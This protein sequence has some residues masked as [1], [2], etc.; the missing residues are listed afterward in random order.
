MLVL[1][2]LAGCLEGA[3]A[4]IRPV[5]GDL[6]LCLGHG[7]VVEG[8][9][10]EGIDQLVMARV[11]RNGL[12]E[13]DIVPVQVAAF[14]RHTAQPGEAVR[15]QCV[16]VQRRHVRLEPLPGAGQE[17]VDLCTRAAET[18]HAVGGGDRHQNLLRIFRTNPGCV[19]G[20]GF[21]VGALVRVLVGRDRGAFALGRGEKALA[22]LTVIV[23]KCVI[24]EF[25]D[26]HLVQSMG[27]VAKAVK[28][29]RVANSRAP[30][31]LP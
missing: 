21:A 24:D 13:I 23:G 3:F 1:T 15:V 8:R 7:F 20:E 5:S 2:G 18:F 17:P 30:A 4:M 25:E 22:R 28:G 9:R 31:P 19:T 6:F 12:G 26:A 11:F 14:F 16:D 29:N 10:D 27:K